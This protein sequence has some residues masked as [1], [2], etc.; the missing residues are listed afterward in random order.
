MIGTTTRS[1]TDTYT[2]TRARYIIGKVYEDLIGLMSAGLITKDRADQIR[3]DILYLLSKKVLKYFE[4]QFT[5][6]GVEIGG[7]HYEVRGDSTIF[8]DDESGNIDFWGLS[9]SVYVGLLVQ[10]DYSSPNINEVNR[11]LEA[12][13]WGSGN[14]LSGSHQYSK[15]YSKDGFGVK[16]SIIGKW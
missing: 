14:A 3:S 10:L 8:M 11:Q 6:F 12:W 4:L 2:E 13:G 16:Q 7:L 15:S 1:V 5:L 9:K